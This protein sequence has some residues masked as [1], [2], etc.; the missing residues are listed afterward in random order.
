MI[1]TSFISPSDLK[2]RLYLVCSVKWFS[3]KK[4]LYLQLSIC[5]C[6]FC[7]LFTVM[8]LPR[9][10]RQ[11]EGLMGEQAAVWLS[12]EL[13]INICVCAKDGTSYVKTS[14]CHYCAHNWFVWEKCDKWPRIAKNKGNILQA[15]LMFSILHPFSVLLSWFLY[16]QVI[17]DLIMFR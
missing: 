15:T 5:S 1:M 11:A 7:P 2:E 13:G 4:F 10:D 3:K 9:R 17:P 14:M 8:V 12:N 6:V 16:P